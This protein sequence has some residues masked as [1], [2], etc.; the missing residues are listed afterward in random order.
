M[1][2]KKSI[3]VQSWPR[4]IL[5]KKYKRESLGSLAI[6]CEPVKVS[7][8]NFKFLLLLLRLF[9]CDCVLVRV[10][11]LASVSLES[12]VLSSPH[13]SMAFV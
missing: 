11:S 12:R 13:E 4:R 10:L 7:G 9:M 8:R 6:S 1:Y 5:L 3:G 2:A